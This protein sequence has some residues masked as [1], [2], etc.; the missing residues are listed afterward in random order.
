MLELNLFDRKLYLEVL[1][2]QTQFWDE[3][4]ESIAASL[5]GL[6]TRSWFTDTFVTEEE[7]DEDLHFGR[8]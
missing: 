5:S 7:L 8:A 1:Q 4:A 6:A 2:R 3:L